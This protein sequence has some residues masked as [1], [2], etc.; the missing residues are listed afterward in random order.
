M[1]NL[2]SSD[3]RGSVAAGEYERQYLENVRLAAELEQAKYLHS[4]AHEI[5][6][7]KHVEIIRLGA[8]LANR[9]ATIKNDCENE[10]ECRK[11]LSAYDKSD[12][13][14]VVPIADLIELVIAE[15][16]SLRAELH[17]VKEELRQT[18]AKHAHLSDWKC[19]NCGNVSEWR[20]WESSLLPG[21]H[22]CDMC[23]A[24][25]KSGTLVKV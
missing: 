14:G 9:D 17:R 15:R 12:S 24:A 23:F 8:A 4:L 1:N 2:P 3:H 21:Q 11:L 10:Q 22:R 25:G 20:N 5:A 6:V 18:I 7:Q 16:D 19:V 13:N